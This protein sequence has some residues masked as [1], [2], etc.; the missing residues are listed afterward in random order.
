MLLIAQWQN[1]QDEGELP[2]RL[3]ECIYAEPLQLPE[4][5]SAMS[6]CLVFSSQEAAKKVLAELIQTL[7]HGSESI[8]EL[9]NRVSCLDEL[10]IAVI[11]S[12]YARV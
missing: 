4:H 11:R 7:L 9:F 3:K 12:V 6:S 8:C 10:L 5:S 1:C 2:L